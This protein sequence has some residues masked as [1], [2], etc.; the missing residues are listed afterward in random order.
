MDE[1]CGQQENIYYFL[2]DSNWFTIQFISLNRQT[3]EPLRGFQL[4]WTVVQVKSNTTDNQCLLSNEYFYCKKTSNSTTPNFCIHRSLLCDGHVHCQPLSNDDELPSNCFLMIPTRSRYLLPIASSS[5][6]HQHLI[7]IITI[8]ILCMTMLCIALV[9]IFL[10]IK[11]KRRQQEVQVAKEI[12]NNQP[13]RRRQ[14]PQD[15]LSLRKK[16]IQTYL[17]DDEENNQDLIGIHMMEQAVT[18]V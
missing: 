5:F 6:L 11:M 16:S 15:N 2:T 4:L 7:L 18:T 9:L 17:D 10:L 8:F 12:R 3:K 13:R 1:L 14:N